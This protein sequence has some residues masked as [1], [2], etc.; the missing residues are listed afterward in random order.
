MYSHPDK[1]LLEKLHSW[2]EFNH[3]DVN[4]TVHDMKK[5]YPLEFW[6]VWKEIKARKLKWEKPNEFYLGIVG[7]RVRDSYE[8]YNLLN[9]V[10]RKLTNDSIRDIVIISG[11]CTRGGDKFATILYKTFGTKKLWFPA[12][13]DKYGNKAGF[14]RNTDIALVSEKIVA[15]VRQ[16]RK[17][18]TED[19]IIKFCARQGHTKNLYLL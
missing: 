18:G 17:G 15:L 11:L 3:T 19:T 2:M 16:D 1:F 9:K 13:W 12:E 6:D 5:E 10:Y 8:D 14:L 7:S 4:K